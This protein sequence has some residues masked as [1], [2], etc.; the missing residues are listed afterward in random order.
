MYDAFVLVVSVVYMMTFKKLF[1]GQK[2]PTAAPI[3]RQNVEVTNAEWTERRTTKRRMPKRRM[4]QNVEWKKRRMGQ[5]VEW[6]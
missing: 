3:H 2:G 6:N 1:G 4:G 5:N